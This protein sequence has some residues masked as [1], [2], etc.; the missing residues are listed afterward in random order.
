MTDELKPRLLKGLHYFWN[1]SP[2]K[3][4]VTHVVHL[5]EYLKLLDQYL[6]GKRELTVENMTLE[7]AKKVFE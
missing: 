5:H 6:N 1:I 3:W 2:A 4:N 7:E